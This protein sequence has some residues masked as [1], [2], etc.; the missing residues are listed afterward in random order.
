MTIDAQ[1]DMVAISLANA[2]QRR[3]NIS[4]QLKNVPIPSVIFDALTDAPASAPYNPREALAKKNRELT[5]G[6]I[7]CFAS[8]YSVLHDFVERGAPKYRI[9]IEDDLFLDPLFWWRDIPKLM[10]TGDIRFFKLYSCSH[11][12]N[13]TIARFRDRSLLRYKVPPYGTQAY[14]VSQQGARQFIS[15]VD[16]IERPVD[17]YLDSFWITGIPVYGIHPSPVLELTGDSTIQGRHAPRLKREAGFR[18]QMHRQLEKYRRQL[19]N[20]ACGI[21][22]REMARRFADMGEFD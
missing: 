21:H 12:R 8:H 10:N 6:E 4:E 19:A 3:R 17:D 5:K 15:G 1:I 16:S 18:Y 13:K 7:G 11:T 22:D 9:I 2:V 20:L 14:V